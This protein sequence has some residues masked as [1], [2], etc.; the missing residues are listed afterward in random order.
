MS[1]PSLR[2][3][4]LAQPEDTGARQPSIT[5]ANVQDVDSGETDGKAKLLV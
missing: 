3:P 2:A 1:P 4:H 5:I